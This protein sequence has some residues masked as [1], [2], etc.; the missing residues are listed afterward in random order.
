MADTFSVVSYLIGQFCLFESKATIHK[1]SMIQ[2]SMCAWVC[3]AT[4]IAFLLSPPLPL[5]PSLFLLFSR[6]QQW[7]PTNEPILASQRLGSFM[8][9]VVL[10]FDT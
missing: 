7:R 9:F 6:G 8:W 4:L 10:R 1:F 3:Y 5:F 2:I